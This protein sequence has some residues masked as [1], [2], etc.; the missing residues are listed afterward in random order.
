MEDEFE[1]Y[2]GFASVYDLFMD[3]I[4]YDAWS[5]YVQGMLKEYGID[6]G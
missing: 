2:G 1:V 3:E 5:E 4:P 6:S